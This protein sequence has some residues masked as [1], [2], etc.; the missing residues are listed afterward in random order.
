MAHT[1]IDDLTAAVDMQAGAVVS[2]VVC[3]E[4][5]VNVTVFGLD[6]GEG[7]T[8]HRAARAAVAQVISGRLRFTADGDEMDAGPGFWIYIAPNTRH[9]LT[10]VEPTVMLLTLLTVGE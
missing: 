7:L 1:V 2:K 3:R 4:P 8:E 6:A 5:G 9:A 10:A